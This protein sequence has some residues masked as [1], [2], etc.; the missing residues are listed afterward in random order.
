MVDAQTNIEQVAAVGEGIATGATDLDAPVTTCPGMSVRD[1]VAH[2]AAFSSWVAVL[3]R[4]GIPV[5]P[6]AGDPSSDVVADHSAAIEDLLGAMR[7]ADPDDDGWSWGRD[8]HKRFWYRRAAQ[9]LSVHHWDLL[10][11]HGRQHTIPPA[12]AADGVDEF[13]FEFGPPNPFFQGAAQHF[14]GDGERF[15]YAA[16]DLEHAWTVTAR[17]ESFDPH[18][19]EVDVEARGTASDLVLFMWGRVPPTALEVDGDIS[20]LQRWS[21]RISI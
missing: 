20:L 12:I 18:D 4:D 3:I 17:P 10:H 9:E 5:A 14:G 7:S 1:L 11:A 15:R 8:Q 21:E 6:S 16:T 19:G 13:L 2:T